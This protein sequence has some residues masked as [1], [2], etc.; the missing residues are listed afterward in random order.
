MAEDEDLGGGG[1]ADED[2]WEPDEGDVG[3]G[4]V[5]EEF[6]HSPDGGEA[7]G[8]DG[9]PDEGASEEDALELVEAAQGDG[10]G[11]DEQGEEGSSG[12]GCEGDTGGCD[13]LVADDLGAGEVGYE[14]DGVDDLSTAEEFAVGGVGGLAAE[15]GWVPLL[16]DK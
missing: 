5:G 15:H 8:D 4:V 9:G 16:S 11:V 12:E 3:Y 14:A 7:H 10:A 13:G 1:D 2:D 6:G